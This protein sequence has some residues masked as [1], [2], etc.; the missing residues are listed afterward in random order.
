MA[1]QKSKKALKITAA[2]LAVALVAAAAAYPIAYR[3]RGNLESEALPEGF[4]EQL[5]AAGNA[6]KADGADVRILSAN[7]LV[8]Y[9]SWG[10]SPVRPRAKQFIEVVRHFEPDVA[11][12]QEAS[13]DWHACIERNLE[14]YALLHPQNNL[15]QKSLTTLLYNT[16][17]LTLIDSGRQA[18]SVGDGT[19][20]RAVTWGVFETKADGKRF[21]VTSTHLNL[22]RD[23]ETRS[24]EI[25]TMTQQVAE[26]T[27][28]V[29]GLQAQYACPVFC[30]GDYNAM[31]N[32]STRGYSAGDEI[33]RLLAETYTD[34]KFAAAARTAGSVEAFDLPTW[35]HIFMQGTAQ[36]CAFRVLS[37]PCLQEMSDHF[38]IFADVALS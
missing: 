35:D 5:S 8:G 17:T 32:D 1:K 23:E 6:Q 29:A 37:E 31:E 4:S 36:V 19:Q 34:T 26:L 21:A 14:H 13:F 16:E 15:V 38:P 25:E 28:L 10:G 33:Y 27:E 11:A 9:K 3:V 18:Y 2:V 24:E 7:L 22:V 30:A 20:H 12:L